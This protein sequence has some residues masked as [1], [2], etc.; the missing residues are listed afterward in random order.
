MDASNQRSDDQYEDETP[1]ILS[2]CFRDNHDL[3]FNP[4]LNKYRF[5]TTIALD[6]TKSGDNTDR[7]VSCNEKRLFDHC[8]NYNAKRTKRNENCEIDE[9]ERTLR[10]GF[11]AFVSNQSGTALKK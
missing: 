6:A 4:L 11:P 7:Q 1:I 5:I 2:F 8:S 9:K 3:Y 10:T